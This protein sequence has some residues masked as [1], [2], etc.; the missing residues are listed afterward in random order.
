MI[1]RVA[2]NVCLQQCLSA[3][4]L[5]FSSAKVEPIFAMV[6]VCF[7]RFCVKPPSAS[8]STALGVLPLLILNDIQISTMDLQCIFRFKLVFFQSLF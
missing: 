8:I 2:P 6:I 3:S 5:P 1:S 7:E 4:V